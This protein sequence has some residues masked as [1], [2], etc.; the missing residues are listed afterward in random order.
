M[1]TADYKDL[2]IQATP[3][4]KWAR[5]LV[6]AVLIL[7]LVIV[8]LGWFGRKYIAKQALTQWC[9]ERDLVCEGHFDRL[10]PGGAV[11]SA[12]SVSSQGYTSFTA[13]EVN[14]ALDWNGLSPAITGIVVTAPN[15]RGTLD[16]RGVRFYGLEKLGQSN[17]S[18]GGGLPMPPVTITD[19]RLVLQTSAGEIGA[20][21][22]MKGVFPSSGDLTIE[23][24]PVSLSGPEGTLVWSEGIVNIVARNGRL[25][26]DITLDLEE[27]DV[28]GFT[29]SDAHLS[30]VL[31]A[32]LTGEGQTQLVWDGSLSQMIWGEDILQDVATNGRATLARLPEFS[33]DAIFDALENASAEVM[34]E[35]V[36]VAGMN[37]QSLDFKADL[38]G[39]QGL[40]TGPLNL[41]AEKVD[42]FGVKVGQGGLNGHLRRAADTGLTLKANTRLSDA[43]LSPEL[44]EQ[45]L[46]SITLPSVISAHGESLR[47]ALDRALVLFDATGDI[48]ASS[49]ADGWSFT[50]EGPAHVAAESGFEAKAESSGDAP[51]LTFSAGSVNLQGD[52]QA[53]GGGLPVLRGK[54][55]TS[56]GP[57]GLSRLSARQLYIAPWRAGG[58]TL[59]ASLD[60][61]DYKD[62]SD[63]GMTLNVKG[64]AGFS[65]A[66]AGFDFA[67]ATVSGNFLSTSDNSG[68]RISSVDKECLDFRVKNVGFGSVAIG[69]F[70]TDICPEGESF[71]KS[72]N[73]VLTGAVTMGQVEFPVTLSSTQGKAA[74]TGA[75][76]NLTSNRGARVTGRADKVALLLDVGDKVLDLGGEDLSLEI[77]TRKGKPP[78]FSAQL[79]KTDFGGTLVPANVTASNFTFKGTTGDA[80]VR[81]DLQADGVLIQDYR[82]D[83]LY[84]P[85]AADFTATL[86]GGDLVMFGPVRLKS[87]DVVV[88]DTLLHLDVLKMRGT[89]GVEGRNLS[90]MPGGLQPWRLSDRLRGVFTDARGNLTG[91]A[92]FDIDA[93]KINGIGEVSVSDFS[94]QTTRLGRVQG[95]N[96]TVEFEDLLALTTRPRQIIRV[97]ALNPGVPLVNG[98]IMFQLVGGKRLAV[99]SAAFPFAGGELALAPFEW[100][101]GGETQHVEMTAEAIE[102]SE[103]VKA[104][105]LPKTRAEGTVSGRFP[106]NIDGTEINIRS[107]RLKADAEG[108]HIA[109]LG[110]TGESAASA[111]PSARMAFQALQDFDFTVLEL[112]LDGNVRDRI[113]VTLVL[114]G[115][116]RK[117][118]TYGKD[119]QV[120]TGQPFLFNITVDSALGELLRNTQYYTS[121]KGLTDAVVK[122]VEE[123]RNS[124]AE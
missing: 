99:D 60:T 25:E 44:R 91:S 8:A 52:L 95:V 92:E 118:V 115:V 45:L 116:S 78:A 89:A 81:G 75:R 93:G 106:I 69:P 90:F 71:L 102:L 12:V 27:A 35:A 47:V 5:W 62:Q 122:Q 113:T 32:P 41:S 103:L 84:Q 70:A 79:G 76:I 87:G 46:G 50:A 53:S 107:A 121:Q 77:A 30:A 110:E 82:D 108:G 48:S 124:Q 67:S 58:K 83:P 7:M 24:D 4:R 111:D 9:H 64:K 55:E 74:F 119:G 109:Y 10:G 86:E 39:E 21:V 114:E 117:G 19:G 65:G 57:R 2:E 112:G 6:L 34:A 51:W 98:E 104:L 73:S 3:R 22:E 38:V 40:V 49:T 13:D 11:L 80:G 37:G 120:L 68:L 28:Q 56:V 61:L 23:L 88:A 100:T 26:G 94:F 29:A 42:G 54:L 43:E 15:L 18:R 97:G 59:S 33:T 1:N 36:T 20:S 85:L 105:K 101:L 14:A 66:L 96:G 63:G 17:G 31:K 72:G 123:K 16:D